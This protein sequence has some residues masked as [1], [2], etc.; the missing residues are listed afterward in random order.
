MISRPKNA[1]CQMLPRDFPPRIIDRILQSPEVFLP[2]HLHP[3]SLYGRPL[4]SWPKFLAFPERFAHG[5]PLAR[6]APLSSAIKQTSLGG[7]SRTKLWLNVNLNLTSYL[8]QGFFFFFSK[9][10]F[11]IGTFKQCLTKN[12]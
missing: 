2:P 3:D 6:F 10:H 8:L 11:A 4:T 9:L 5:A 1:G 12:D 7:Q